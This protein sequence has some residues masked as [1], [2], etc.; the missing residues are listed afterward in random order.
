MA[1]GKDVHDAPPRAPLPDLDDGV[2]ALV[3][4]ALEGFDEELAVERVAHLEPER[5]RGELGGHQDLRV[6][7][8]GCRD[9]DQR[10]ARRE[11]LAGEGALG[12]GLALAPAAPEARLALRE[13]ERRGAEEFQ[14]LRP[15]VGVEDRRDEHEPRARGALEELGDGECAGAA[16]EADDAQADGSLG[17]RLGEVVKRRPVPQHPAPSRAYQ[18]TARSSRGRS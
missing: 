10:L 12:V 16:R 17:E 1:R 15:A 7:P 8:G 11:P 13:L 14:I 9:D 4:A 5:A 2:H 6:E 18:T 3:A